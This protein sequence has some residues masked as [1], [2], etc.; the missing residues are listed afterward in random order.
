MAFLDKKSKFSHPPMLIGYNFSPEQAHKARDEGKLLTMRTETSLACNLG[1]IYCNSNSGEAPPGEISFETIKEV[2]SQVKD[3][4]GESVVVIGGGEPTIYPYFRELIKYINEEKNMAPVIFTN[5]TTMDLDLAKFLFD[6]N[7]SVLT[8]L[9]SLKEER[10]DFLAN[11]PGTFKKIHEGLENLMKVGFGNYNNGKLRLGASFVTCSLTLDETPDIWAF[12]RDRN[13]YPNQEILTPRGRAVADSSGLSLTLNQIKDV[14]N[15]LL[16]FDQEKYGYTWLPYMPLTG[17]GCLQHMY[18]VY[19]TSMGF[20]R[21]CA[22]VD[23]ELFNVKDMKIKDII[24]SPFF[25]LARNID[26]YLEGKCKECEY[27]HKCIGCR[28]YA[29]SVGKAQGLSDFKAMKK[30]DLIC[31][32]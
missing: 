27:I 29:H 8:K 21:S 26:K 13:M 30:E 28:G 20:V 6:Q 1:C 9:D 23:I 12:C 17:H 3:L 4:G 2:I 22:D 7:V 25:Q 31:W 14:K 32:K 10:Q 16:K 5:T 18:S 15:K 19:L 24:K 11:E